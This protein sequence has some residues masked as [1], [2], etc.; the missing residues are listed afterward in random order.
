MA[1]KKQGAKFDLFSRIAIG[2]VVT[3]IFLFVLLPVG[4]MV[5]RSFEE[6]GIN[7]YKSLLDN[8]YVRQIVLNTI[9]LGNLCRCTRNIARFYLGLYPSASEFQ[10]KEDPARSE[11]SALSLTT[12]CI[13]NCR[14]RSLR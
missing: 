10:G 9:W 1:L 2:L 12:I 4:T 6:G 7:V 8:P 5:L 14:D 3:I 11:L 13:R